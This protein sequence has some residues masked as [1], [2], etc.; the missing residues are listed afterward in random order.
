MG[1]HRS[2]CCSA[3]PHPG[4]AVAVPDLG[5]PPDPDLLHRR[6][7]T[8]RHVDADAPR[9]R[10]ALP[11]RLALDCRGWPPRPLK[12]DTEAL[13]WEACVSVGLGKGVVTRYLEPRRRV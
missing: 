7:R 3:G 5:A 11:R 1:A 9:R 12:S 6:R 2:R 10:Q 4:D 8:L 13:V